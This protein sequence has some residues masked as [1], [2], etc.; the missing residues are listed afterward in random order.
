MLKS[1]AVWQYCRGQ[2]PYTY[3][4]WR[5]ETCEIVKDVLERV[6]LAVQGFARGIDHI[7]IND[8]IMETRFVHSLDF[9]QK[10]STVSFPDIQHLQHASP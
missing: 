2:Q 5:M 10:R 4:E 7:P 3:N 8:T 9:A 1:T 6:C